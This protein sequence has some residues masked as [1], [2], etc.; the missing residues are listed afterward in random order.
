MFFEVILYKKSF[1]KTPIYD[2]KELSFYYE[3]WG[4]C[5]ISLM[6]NDSYVG[7]DVDV[8]TMAA[9]QISGVS[10]YTNWLRKNIIPPRA[11]PGDLIIKNITEKTHGIGYDYNDISTKISYNKTN[12]WICM[13]I[14][15]KD[16]VDC[17]EF[18][19]NTI[20]VVDNGKLIAIWIKPVF[21]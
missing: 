13:G 16:G 8:N 18:E 1:T 10:P 15:K 14:E 7:I 21:R 4:N 19:K 17:V 6:L 5:D 3:P 12:G 9:I 20:A 2:Y 11:Y